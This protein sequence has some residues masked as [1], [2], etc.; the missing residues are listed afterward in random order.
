[1]HVTRT[2]QLYQ[3][4][5]N[6]SGVPVTF[7]GQG[8]SLLIMCLIWSETKSPEFISHKILYQLLHYNP[9]IYLGHTQLLQTLDSCPVSCEI[10]YKRDSSLWKI[11]KARQVS[12]RPGVTDV[13][14]VTSSN[15]QWP[16]EAVRYVGH[17]SNHGFWCLFKCWDGNHMVGSE[18]SVIFLLHQLMLEL[19]LLQMMAQRNCLRTKG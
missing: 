5:L 14:T 16:I 11:S 17:R 7:G 4:Q 1:M 10:F 18:A 12:G 2:T 19:L 6:L 9:G 15:D 13:F 3:G 8:S